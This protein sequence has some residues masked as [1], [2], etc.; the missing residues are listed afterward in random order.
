MAFKDIANAI[1]KSVLSFKNRRV[2]CPPGDVIPGTGVMVLIPTIMRSGTHLLIDTIINNFSCYRRSPLYVDLDRLFD[3]SVGREEKVQMLLRGG[4]YVVK[5]HYPQTDN[6]PNR[7]P[8]MLKVFKC[9][10][11]I[12]VRRD[13]NQAVRSALAWGLPQAI[14]E[15]EYRT[16]IE[17]FYEFWQ[18]YKLLVLD[19]KELV[20]P[21]LFP[22]AVAKIGRYLRC[23]PRSPLI[24]NIPKNRP[25][26]IYLAKGA[27]RLLGKYAPLV[28]TTINFNRTDL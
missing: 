28:N 1:G 17:R 12:T 27:T 13:V 20:N 7:C 26:A 8:Y 24:Y 16:S 18:D 10:K 21:A 19:F 15:D 3:Y 4:S 5:T 25:L 6:Q 11:I 14:N 23:K 2:V 22:K 9:C